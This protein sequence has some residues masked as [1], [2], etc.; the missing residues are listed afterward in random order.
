[1]ADIKYITKKELRSLLLQVERAQEIFAGT[2]VAKRR[3][4]M[5]DIAAM[6]EQD[7]E[8]LAEI[9]AAESN[10]ETGRLLTEIT[11]T[12]NQLRYY[13]NFAAGEN[14]P[15][16]IIDIPKKSAALPELRKTQVPL[17][18]VVVFGSSNFPF[19]YSTTG[20]DTA[21]GLAAG[22]CVVVKAHSSHPQTSEAVAQIIHHCVEK[23]KLPKAVFTHVHVKD[24]AIT[25]MLVKYEAVKAVGF[26]GGHGGGMQ[27]FKWANERQ[28]PIPVFAEMGSTNPVC[29]LSGTLAKNYASIAKQLADAVTNSAGQFCTKPGLIFIPEGA[30]AEKFKNVLLAAVHEKPAYKL[31][32]TDV[33]ENYEKNLAAGISNKKVKVLEERAAAND[34]FFPVIAATDAAAF[35]KNDKLAE[36]VFGPFSMLVSYKN[37]QELVLCINKMKGQLTASVFGGAG[38]LRSNKVLLQALQS[39]CGRLIFNGVPTGV[40]ITPAMQHGG[41]FPATTDIRF[42]SVGATGIFRFVRPVCYQ[43]CPDALLPPELKNANPLQLLRMINGKWSKRMINS[44]E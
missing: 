33:Q 37:I 22:C 44:R 31:L 11:R 43:N 24:Y 35:L 13:S 8:T 14:F 29:I 27:M 40:G 16:T 28:D 20:G 12:A 2:T 34:N 38:E 19:A 1:M 23:Q 6:L 36:E 25:E 10:L 39:I 9:A 17:G 32:N 15:Q 4:L 21:C 5:H 3:A 42:T 41:P 18:V 30:A 26:T 7:A